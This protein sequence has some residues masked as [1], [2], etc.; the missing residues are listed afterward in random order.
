MYHEVSNPIHIRCLHL[1]QLLPGEVKGD[2]IL[3][4]LLWEGNSKTAF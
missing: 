2:I 1:L 3:M 4:S